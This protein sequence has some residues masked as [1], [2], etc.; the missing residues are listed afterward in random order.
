MLLFFL[1]QFTH[2][3][4]KHTQF[5]NDSGLWCCFRLLLEAAIFFNYLLQR[6][7]FSSLGGRLCRCAAAAT[8]RTLHQL[9]LLSKIAPLNSTR[10]KN[11]NEYAF[12]ALARFHSKAQVFLTEMKLKLADAAA[13]QRWVWMP[14]NNRAWIQEMKAATTLVLWMIFIF[15]IELF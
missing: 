12:K 10:A 15:V 4:R 7:L 3:H 2:N 8:A 5:Q 14:F 11:K 13:G 1:V 9:K 6:S